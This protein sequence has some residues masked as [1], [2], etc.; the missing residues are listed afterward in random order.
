MPK[1]STKRTKSRTSTGASKKA[2][3]KSIA[4]SKAE[5]EKEKEEKNKKE[6][7]NEKEEK[8]IQVDSSK[9][10]KFVFE[11]VLCGKCCKNET[12]NITLTDLDRWMA[13]NT[14]YRVFHLLKLDENENKLRIIL[15]KDDDGYCNLFHRDNKKCTIYEARPIFC[16]AYPLGFNGK[17]YFI[18]TKDCDG[19]NK[20]KLDKERL[21]SIRNS[22]FDEYIANRQLDRVLPIIRQIIMNTLIEQS[23]ALLNKLSDDQQKNTNDNK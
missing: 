15:K 10:P 9:P 13:D 20:G 7:K 12:V 1:Q 4:E 14:I 23:Q 11:C 6:E 16:Q 21:D 3:K 19:L 5:P 18:K 2:K 8:E 22:A 17:D